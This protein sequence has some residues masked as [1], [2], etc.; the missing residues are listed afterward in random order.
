RHC[1]L[2]YQPTAA[3]PQAAFEAAFEAKLSVAEIFARIEG[4]V[5]E[6]RLRAC[7]DL[8]N[9]A[10]LA[11]SEN[12]ISV[13]DHDRLRAFTDCYERAIAVDTI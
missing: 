8:T 1:E 7:N 5:A 10:K 9:L 11:L 3:D 6:G 2:A 4:A 12:I 13:Q